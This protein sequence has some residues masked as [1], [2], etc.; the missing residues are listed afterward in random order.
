MNVM[1]ANMDAMESVKKETIDSIIAEICAATQSVDIKNCVQCY[2]YGKSVKQIKQEL[3]KFRKA[4]LQATFEHL[5][6]QHECMPRTKPDIVNDIVCRIQN[7]LPETCDS[8]NQSYRTKYGDD[9]VL[10]CAICGQEAHLPCLLEKLGLDHTDRPSYKDVEEMIN[11]F[12]FSSLQ[13]ICTPC[14]ESTIPG[15]NTDQYSA[16]EVDES[17][18]DTSQQYS[19]TVL[20][21]I[22]NI[23]HEKS[24]DDKLKTVCRFY[25]QGT[26]KYGKKGTECKY[27]HPSLCRKLLQHGY[28][29]SHGCRLKADECSYHH[30]IMCRNSIKRGFCY[31]KNCTKY[32]VQG[33]KRNPD[34][35]KPDKSP[36]RQK[37]DVKMKS[38]K[39]NAN[40]YSGSNGNFTNVDFLEYLKRVKEE[41]L[42]EMDSRMYNLWFPPL[43][44]VANPYQRSPLRQPP[45]FQQ[46]AAPRIMS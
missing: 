18:I 41:I 31:K 33:T 43:P 9:H 42:K 22:N 6:W 45:G 11:P 37:A 29:A 39:R 20:P 10:A 28:N 16:P 25:N 7:F 38:I 30:P 44:Q 36:P 24:D 23:N 15:Y 19:K 4:P 17:T 26:C 3:M 34:K 5:K 21:S 27:S 1:M 46:M 13:Y 35:K 8:C 2:E 12:G 14:G 32:H 40:D